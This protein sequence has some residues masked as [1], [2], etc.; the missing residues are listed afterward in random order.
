MS[1]RID[2]VPYDVPENFAMFRVPIVGDTT[3]PY[4]RNKPKGVPETDED[5]QIRVQEDVAA[6][7]V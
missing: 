4:R 2:R 7:Q 1:I 5:M 3:H 6:R